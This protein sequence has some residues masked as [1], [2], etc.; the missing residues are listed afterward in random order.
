MASSLD[1]HRQPSAAAPQS[2]QGRVN[3]DNHRHALSL[4]LE[5]N[6]AYE[7]IT[8]QMFAHRNDASAMRDLMDQMEEIRHKALDLTRS[9][10]AADETGR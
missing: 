4:W 1:T 10:L 6:R 8:V 9:L 3:L 2:A 7:S 5:W